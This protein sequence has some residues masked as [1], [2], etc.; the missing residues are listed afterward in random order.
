MDFPLVEGHNTRCRITAKIEVTFSLATLK[1]GFWPKSN[2]TFP[3]RDREQP[4]TLLEGDLGTLERSGFIKAPSIWI[5]GNI[6][7]IWFDSIR[8]LLDF[9]ERGHMI[10]SKTLEWII[11]TRLTRQVLDWHNTIWTIVLSQTLLTH[12][13]INRLSGSSYKLS[14]DI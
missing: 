10:T 6:H 9:L 14:H 7:I 11:F 5:N 13:F 2:C 8:N 3:R 4:S 12:G 1:L